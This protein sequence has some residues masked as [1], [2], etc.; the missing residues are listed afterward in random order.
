MWFSERF[1]RMQAWID[2]IL[3]ASHKDHIVYIRGNEVRVTRGQLAWAAE[4]LAQRWKWDRKTVIRFLESLEKQGMIGQQKS[5]VITVITINKYDLYQSEGQ[6]TPQQRG[7]Q[8]PNRRDT[9]KKGKNGKNET[10]A[11]SKENCP[12]CSGRGEVKV[13]N[14][15]IPCGQCREP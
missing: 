4:V 15:W 5:R 1:T 12:N 14:T 3:L 10:I 9:N 2:M 7:Q 8:K 13:S 11:F 6:Q